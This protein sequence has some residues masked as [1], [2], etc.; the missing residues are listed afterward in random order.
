MERYIILVDVDRPGETFEVEL[1]AVD[2]RVMK[3]AVPNTVVQFSLFRRERA[4]EGALGGRIFRFTPAAAGRQER[5]RENIQ[6]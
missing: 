1:L 4:Y 5:I 2:E 6:K 3:V